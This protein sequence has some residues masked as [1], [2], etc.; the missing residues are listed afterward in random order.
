MRVLVDMKISRIAGR[1]FAQHRIPLV[2]SG[3]V[4]AS[5]AES[6]TVT[7]TG[8]RNIDHII[9]ASLLP[10]IAAA[11]LAGRGRSGRARLCVDLDRERGTFICSMTEDGGRE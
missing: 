2:W 7:D 10:R 3:D 9:N 6:C 11:L 4:A 1:L 8:A 5:I